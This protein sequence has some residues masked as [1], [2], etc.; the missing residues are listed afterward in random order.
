MIIYSS[1]VMVF[2][3]LYDSSNQE[4]ISTDTSGEVSIQ[5]TFNS[6]SSI[7]F[8]TNIAQM[9]L[10][11]FEHLSTIQQLSVESYFQNRFNAIQMEKRMPLKKV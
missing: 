6:Q 5:F 11:I 10:E 3:H 4:V 1:V 7:E 9:A 8:L 2:E